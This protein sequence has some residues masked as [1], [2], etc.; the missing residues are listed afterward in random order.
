M[1][2]GMLSITFR[3]KSPEEIIELVKKSGLTAIEWGGD[4][5]VLPGDVQT[6]E[7]VGKLTREAGL[8]VAAYGSYYKC[9]AEDCPF[10]DVLASAAALGTK[11]IRVWAGN[12]NFEDA[13]EQEREQVYSYLTYAVEQS[14]KLGITVATEMH[15]NTLTNKLDGTLEMLKRVPGLKTY[16]QQSS[17]DLTVDE[18]CEVIKTLGDSVVNAH[19]NYWIEYTQYPLSEIAD[20]LEKYIPALEAHTNANAFMIEFVAGSSPEQ[21]FDDANTLLSAGKS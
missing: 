15:I 11:V 3:Q 14:S 19:I 20:R 7:K 1:E 8:T 5:H 13:T 4:I 18:E 17:Y 10:D 6:A 9:S 2:K 21:F 16:W 12:K